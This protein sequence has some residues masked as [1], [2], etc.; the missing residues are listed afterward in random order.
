MLVKS[1]AL[2]TLLL[3]VRIAPAQSTVPADSVAPDPAQVSELVIASHI[4]ASLGLLDAYGH[5]SVRDSHNP[6]RYLMSRAVPAAKVTADDIFV[7]DLDSTPLKGN[8]A[9]SFWERFIHGEI[10]KAQPGV[11]AVVHSHSPDMI[12]F[13]VID[14]PLRPMIHV[15]GFMPSQVKVFDIRP[16]FGD[17]EMLIET[18]EMGRALAHSLGADSMILMRGHGVVIVGP[19]LHAAVFRSYYSTIDARTEQQALQLGHGAVKFLSE[20]ENQRTSSLGG[21]DRAWDLWKSDAEQK[22]RRETGNK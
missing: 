7:Y 15:A 9:E 17:T 1:V 19:S 13:A 11:M 12:P 5:V 6:N 10:Y 21:I 18:P 14:V 22:P 2:I 3:F 4:L 16:L 8:K 20:G